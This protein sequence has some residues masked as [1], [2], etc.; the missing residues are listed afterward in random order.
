MK[1]ST[2]HAL[3]STIVK[4]LFEEWAFFALVTLTGHRFF[5]GIEMIIVS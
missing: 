3:S 1:I 4:L 2:L 5:Y